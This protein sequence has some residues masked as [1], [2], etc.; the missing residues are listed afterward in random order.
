MIRNNINAMTNTVYQIYQS[1]RIIR[2]FQ[3]LDDNLDEDRAAKM[4]SHAADETLF[5]PGMPCCAYNDPSFVSSVYWEGP[6]WINLDYMMLLG[7]QRYGYGALAEEMR[8]L[9]LHWCDREKRG[10]FEYY[11]SVTGEGLGA[12]H[13]GWT[14]ACIA[15]LILAGPMTAKYNAF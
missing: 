12:K 14:A 8:Q 5:Y 13:F 7:L 10:L 11:D 4:A 9:L 6:T 15:E 3:H 2:F 1:D